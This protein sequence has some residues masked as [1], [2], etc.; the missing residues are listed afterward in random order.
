M[1]GRLEGKVAVITGTGRGIAR[2]VALRFSAEGAKIV[3]CDIDEEAA[4]ETVEIVRQAGGEMESLH[5]L[6]LREEADARRLAEFATEQF[7]GIDILYNNAMAMR[8]GELE[9]LPLEDWKFTLESTLTIHYLVSKHIV[10][11]LRTRGGGSIIFVGSI[12]GMP[13]GAGYPGNL[14]F[15]L[16]YACAKAGVLRMT[17]LLANQLGTAGIRVN[18]I[19]PG[20]IGTDQGL[21]FFG[22]P[23]TETRRVSEI[24]SLLG[25]IGEPA[26]IADAALFLASDDS[27]WVTGHNLVIDG[28]YVASGGYGPA[29]MRDKDVMAPVIGRFAN[30]DDGV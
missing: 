11:S 19:S 23:G 27:R 28:G 2:E 6:D 10:P 20:S 25:R 13:V 15:L 26:D 8:I 18:S 7:G 16:S 29:R 3:G 1:S 22:E 30:I 12:T 21:A 24:G 4:D 5:P 17:T 9:T 14:E